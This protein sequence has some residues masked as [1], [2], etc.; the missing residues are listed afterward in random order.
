V[1]FGDGGGKTVYKKKLNEFV[2]SFNGFIGTMPQLGA[3]RKNKK[4]AS[5]PMIEVL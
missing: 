5:K 2:V 3:S 1:S 4:M